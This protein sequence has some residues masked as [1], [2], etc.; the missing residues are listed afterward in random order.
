MFNDDDHFWLKE[1]KLSYFKHFFID[2][3]RRDVVSTRNNGR[4]GRRVRLT[5]YFTYGTRLLGYFLWGYVR[6][7]VCR[8]KSATVKALEVNMSEFILD[9]S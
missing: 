4:I 8:Y 6:D 2:G 9:T 5:I 1:T 7:H 3:V